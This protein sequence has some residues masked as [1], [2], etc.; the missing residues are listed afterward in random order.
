MS[1]ATN[2]TAIF[3]GQEPK[4]AGELSKIELVKALNWYNQNKAEKDSLKYAS[5]YFKKKHKVN[6][7]PVITDSYLT[8]GFCCRIVQNGGALPEQNQAWFKSTT[9]ELIKKSKQRKV[10]ETVDAPVKNAPN[11]QQRMAEKVNE[12]AGELEGAIDDYIDSDF[13]RAPS[14]YAI[15]QD[16]A[17]GM[18]ANR[19]VEIFKPRRSEYAEVLETNDPEL[20]EGYRNF[21]KSQLKKLVAYC[22]Q[23]ITDALKIAGDS[24]KTRKPRKRKA[25][26][27][28]Q[29]V[30]K[31]NYLNKH[32]SYTSIEPTQV[33]GAMSLWVYNVKTKK[34]GCYI[35]DNALGLAVKG[36]TLLNY[37]ESKSVQ[38][39]LRKPD[40]VLKEVLGGGKVVLRNLL[41]NIRAVESPLT[42]RINKD[43]ILLRVAK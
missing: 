34:L 13:K 16:K 28:E 38:K 33:I 30:A 7:S 42:G 21:N 10:V 9:E 5:D 14:P 4:F 24:V 17:K 6:I 31:L 41:S 11:I 43:T 23:I 22:D 36:S 39:K 25:K 40:V 35:A 20:K 12:I 8:F 27:P 3:T 15:M 32:E 19:I 26:S 18:H 37:T 2:T 1:R 29:V